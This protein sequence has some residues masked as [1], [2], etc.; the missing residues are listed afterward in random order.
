VKLSYQV[1]R[2]ANSA[3]SS[4]AA[5]IESIPAAIMR[6]GRDRLRAWLSVM[7]LSGLDGKPPAVLTLA[8]MRARMC[9]ALGQAAAVPSPAT[10]FM[11]GLFSTL[12]ILFNAPLDKLLEGLPLSPGVADAIV[13]RS[14]QL[15]ASIDAVVAYERGEWTGARCEWLT[16]GDF[17]AAFRSALEW[18]QEWETAFS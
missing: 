15:G 17:T 3:L 13:K 4:P 8:L 12:D 7:A 6:L 16:P 11:A 1:L 18:T 2:F 5:A 14:G 9:E 10:W